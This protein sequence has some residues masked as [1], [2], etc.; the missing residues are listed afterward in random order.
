M[1]DKELMDAWRLEARDIAR[2][3]IES[4]DDS[5]FELVVPKG[6]HKVLADGI[7]RRTMATIT[8]GFSALAGKRITA[9]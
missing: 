8:K 1:G 2:Y 6:E 9:V 7:I 4:D 5:L 3:D